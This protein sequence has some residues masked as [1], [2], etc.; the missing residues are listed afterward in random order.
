MQVFAKVLMLSLFLM[1]PVY[2]DKAFILPGLSLDE[3]TKKIIEESRSKVLDA[4]TEEINGVN[5]HIIKVLTE[6]SRVQYIRVDVDSGK[7]IK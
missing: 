3:T 5:T 1:R 7:I 4:T 2:A 6:D